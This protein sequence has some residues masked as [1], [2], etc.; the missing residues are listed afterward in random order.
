MKKYLVIAAIVAVGTTLL[1]E[2][3]LEGTKLDETVIST[4]R[5]EEVSVM[6][7]AKN[8]TVINSEDIEKRGYKNIEE[9]LVG[10]PGIS[11][12]NGNISIRGQ[13]PNMG[14]KHLVVLVDGIPQ[15]GMD[16]RSFDLDFIPVDK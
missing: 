16:N 15:N 12:S 4:E 6:E 5:Y 11:I 8:I 2:E 3:K 9:A 13:V 10:I 14:D 7:V 1:A